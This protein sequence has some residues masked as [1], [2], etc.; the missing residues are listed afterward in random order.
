MTRAP[1]HGDGFFGLLAWA[2]PVLALAALAASGAALL[3]ATRNADMF[4]YALA[5]EAGAKPQ[6]DYI[7][8]F[9]QAHRLNVA[10]AD[11]GDSL[12][13]AQ[14]T[15]ALAQYR[16]AAASHAPTTAASGAAAAAAHRLACNPLDGNAWLQRARLDALAQ[17]PG[18][19]AAED[20]RMSHIAAPNESWILEPRLDL[21]T[22]L[23]SEG[24]PGLDA[25]YG[26]DLRKFVDFEATD[27]TAAVYVDH[28]GMVRQR[29]RPLI[30]LQPTQRRNRIVSEID[31]LGV[32]Y[33]KP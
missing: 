3:T 6:S 11:C 31:R 26:L 1:H 16:A 12:T 23:I 17:T 10:R 2:V 5:L 18:A 20:L 32:D 21:E 29:L 14:L 27:R 15:I 28:P 8:R 13:R 9:M 30:D 4:D 33:A 25:A 19:E 7:V 22:A 24:T